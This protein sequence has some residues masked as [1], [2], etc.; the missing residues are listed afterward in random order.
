MKTQSAALGKAS[1]QAPAK[2]MHTTA[3][4]LIP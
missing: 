4:L 1:P 3:F 2:I